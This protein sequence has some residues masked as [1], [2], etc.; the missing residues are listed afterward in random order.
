M[1]VKHLHNKLYYN[2]HILDIDS[3]QHM[4]TNYG[5]FVSDAGKDQE[6]LTNIRGLTQAMMQ[7]GAKPS[8]IAEML[9]SDSFSQIKKNLASAE[10]AQEQLEQAQQQAQQ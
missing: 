6:K 1:K 7:N 2:H 8:V 9:D 10:R 3:M 5:I 4:E